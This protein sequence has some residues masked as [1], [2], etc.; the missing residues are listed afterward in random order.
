MRKIIIS[1]SLFVTLAAATFS[2]AL[3]FMYYNAAY[4]QATTTGSPTTEEGEVGTT[5]ESTEDWIR[6]TVPEGW[7]VDPVGQGARTP[8]GSLVLAYVCPENDAR[9]AIGGEHDCS[10]ATVIMSVLKDQFLNRE[11]EIAQAYQGR[12][13]IASMTVDDYVAITIQKLENYLQN[14]RFLTSTRIQIQDSADRPVD[15]LFT[16][17]SNNA[18][19]STAGKE[20]E[21]ASYPTATS[22]GPFVST[23][24]L[25]TI[26]NEGGESV[27]GFQLYYPYGAGLAPETSEAL[28]QVQE[29]F[30]SFQIV[31]PPPPPTPTSGGVPT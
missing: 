11:R 27:T 12:D 25:F 22:T 17:S 13:V 2:I 14:E 24:V 4:G 30:D 1:L 6:F 31:A 10:S 9:P 23:R 3:L 26:I 19:A 8:T 20:V 16:N 28:E 7:V 21:L 15:I 5:Y 29:I 18:T